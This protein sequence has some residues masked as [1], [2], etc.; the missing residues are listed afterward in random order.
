[1]IVNAAATPPD[2]PRERRFEIAVWCLVSVQILQ[3]ALI[4]FFLLTKLT[5]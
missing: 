3:V 4:I 2:R 5:R 1:M